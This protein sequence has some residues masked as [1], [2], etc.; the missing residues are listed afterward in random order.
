[1]KQIDWILHGGQTG[2]DRGAWL[3]AQLLAKQGPHAHIIK[4]GGIAPK[5][6]TDEKGII[7]ANVREHMRAC[8]SKGY[9]ARTRE[10]VLTASALLLVVPDLGN[11]ARTPGTKLTLELAREVRGLPTLVVGGAENPAQASGVRFWLDH[12]PPWNVTSRRSAG[13]FL[14]VAGPRASLWPEG[15]AVTCSLL[16]QALGHA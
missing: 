5:D 12:L 8:D 11:P 2:V 10:N 9:S 15:E 14:M 4:A 16:V 1:M 7:P 13:F 3:A 6:L